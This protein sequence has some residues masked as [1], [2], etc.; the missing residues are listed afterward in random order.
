MREAHARGLLNGSVLVA[1]HEAVVYEAVFG[2]ADGDGTQ[3][4][5]AEHRFNIGS[6]SKEFSAVG[7]AI[8]AE[9]GLLHLDDPLARFLPSLPA[10]A[11]QVEIGHLLTY[12]S[13]LPP[14]R[15][16]EV[17]GDADILAALRA[18]PEL[19]FEPG[20]DFLYSNH[21]VFLRHRVIESVT[22][23]SYGAFMRTRLFSPCGMDGAVVDPPPGAVPIPKAFDNAGLEDDGEI[24]WSGTPYVTA[25]DLY[26]WSECLA[27]STLLSP[28]SLLMLTRSFEGGKSA[29][30][31]SGVEDGVLQWHGHVGSSYNFEAAYYTN[32]TDGVTVVLLTNN[33]N[34]RV[35]SL[36]MAAAAILKG[37]SVPVPRK[38]LYLALRTAIYHDGF[39]AG[40]ALYDEILTDSRE[41]YDLS[42]E[43]GDFTDTGR[44]LLS[45][46]R[47][48]DAVRVFEWAASL[49]PRDAAIHA[50]LGEAYVAQGDVKRAVLSY[51][52]ALV[53]DPTNAP[54]QEQLDVL[55]M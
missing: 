23:L 22:G 2:H 13:G 28:A 49:F 3:A 7:I 12:T 14:L 25:R 8:L 15:E 50:G 31:M 11:E 5:T 32:R 44:Y 38:S 42:D 24:P 10:W 43:A 53:L 54:V 4:L 48:D 21:N 46:S 6:I 1:H 52:R 27:D 18:L 9:E 35:G 29:L 40:Q 20:T 34:F 51:R 33:K 16:S 37:K 19:A 39:A 26:R 47:V 36:A 45:K 17:A 30:G 41:T 55:G